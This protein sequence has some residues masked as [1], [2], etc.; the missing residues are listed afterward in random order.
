MLKLIWGNQRICS[1]PLPCKE[2]GRGKCIRAGKSGISCLFK[3]EENHLLSQR[4]QGYLQNN[5]EEGMQSCPKDTCSSLLGSAPALYPHPD[6]GLA[7]QGYKNTSDLHTTLCV[8]WGVCP[9]LVKTILK[10]H[11]PLIKY[12]FVLQ[13]YAWIRCH[14]LF[15]FPIAPC[16]CSQAARKLPYWNI[17]LVV[18]TVPNFTSVLHTWHIQRPLSKTMNIKWLKRLYRLRSLSWG[19]K[20]CGSGWV[21]LRS[22]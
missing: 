17:L 1:F 18:T 4:Q 11:F 16:W 3:G 22:I 15:L 21:S 9:L 14:T 7:L 2:I 13:M 12:S 10:S 20:G 5:V 8:N 19:I 6:G